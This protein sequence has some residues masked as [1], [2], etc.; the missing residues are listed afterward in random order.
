MTWE[1]PC[2]ADQVEHASRRLSGPSGEQQDDPAARCPVSQPLDV[3][4]HASGYGSGAVERNRDSRAGYAGSAGA[5]PERRGAAGSPGKTGAD[6]AAEREK[7]RSRAH[8]GRPDGRR[9]IAAGW[10]APRTLDRL[11]TTSATGR[12]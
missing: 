12:S 10:V 4:G 8:S 5:G 3:E 2:L 6:D 1:E 7:E 9:G 11:A